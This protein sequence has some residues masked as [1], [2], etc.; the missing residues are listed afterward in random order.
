MSG[1][2]TELYQKNGDVALVCKAYNGRV[3]AQ[4]LSETLAEVSQQEGAPA[5]DRIAPVALCMCLAYNFVVACI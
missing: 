4:W 2:Q 5:D 1:C 3:V